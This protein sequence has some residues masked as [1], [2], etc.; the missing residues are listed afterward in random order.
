[1]ENQGGGTVTQ[2]M[3][4]KNEQRPIPPKIGKAE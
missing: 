3:E 2:R 4:C 1:M